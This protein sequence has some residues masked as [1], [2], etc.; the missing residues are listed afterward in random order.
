MYHIFQLYT[1]VSIEKKMSCFY[2]HLYKWNNHLKKMLY[3]L[4]FH[5]YSTIYLIKYSIRMQGA[6]L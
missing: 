5:E 1:H 4:L 6:V 2:T 3:L